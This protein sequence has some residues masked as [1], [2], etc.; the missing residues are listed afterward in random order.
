MTFLLPALPT[1]SD[2]RLRL[3]CLCFMVSISVSTSP[4]ETHQDN[5]A[6]CFTLLLHW[7][8]WQENTHVKFKQWLYS[9]FQGTTFHVKLYIQINKLKRDSERTKRERERNNKT[10]ITEQHNKMLRIAL[11]KVTPHVSKFLL[12]AK[13]RPAKL[14]NGTYT[15]TILH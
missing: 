2:S 11:V 3:A 6:N 9:L 5:S 7:F 8:D 13:S 15:Q 10:C 1:C 12:T 14:V 4:T